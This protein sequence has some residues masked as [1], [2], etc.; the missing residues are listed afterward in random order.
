MKENNLELQKNYRNINTMKEL[1]IN[2]NGNYYDIEQY[3]SINSSILGNVKQINKKV[4]L[5]I[6]SFDKF[7]FILLITL[8]IEWFFRKKKG[9]L[10]ELF[11]RKPG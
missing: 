1:A 6:H 4:E 7:W 9:L 3:K 10:Y 2:S 5:D 11:R 8:I